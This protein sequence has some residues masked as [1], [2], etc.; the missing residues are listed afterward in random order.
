MRRKSVLLVLCLLAAATRLTASQPQ[1]RVD[2]ALQGDN[3][4]EFTADIRG[5]GTVTVIMRLSSVEN[6]QGE[7][8]PDNTLRWE[9]REGKSVVLHLLPADPTRPVT[10][11]Y[12]IDWI[13]GRINPKTD[14]SFVYRLPFTDGFTS[15]PREVASHEMRLMRG[16]FRDFKVWEFPLREGQTIYPVRKGEVVRIEGFVKTENPGEAMGASFSNNIYIEHPDGVISRYTMLDSNSL[17]V[18]EGETVYPDTPLARAGALDLENYGVWLATY[19]Y[20]PNNSG[21]HA[22]SIRTVYFDPVFSTV[23]GNVHIKAGSN[24]TPHTPKSLINKEK[25]RKNIFSRLFCRK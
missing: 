6:N 10:A 20:A 9:L 13:Q 19:Y 11:E 17:L 5:H 3:S 23:E 22:G 14:N 21:L 15:V 16:N 18:S 4:L 12:S 7:V 8:N 2:S 1:V 25:T 24:I